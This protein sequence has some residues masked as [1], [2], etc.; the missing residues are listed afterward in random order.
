MTN[1]DELFKV[2]FL[3]LLALRTEADRYRNLCQ[4]RVESAS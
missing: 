2:S 4:Q 1:V 3:P